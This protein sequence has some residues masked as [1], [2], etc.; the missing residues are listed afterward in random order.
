MNNFSHKY[1]VLKESLNCALKS[2][3]IPTPPFVG[4]DLQTDLEVVAAVKESSIPRV[5]TTNVCWASTKTKSY[6]ALYRRLPLQGARLNTC[7]RH[8]NAL[9]RRDE[10]SYSCCFRNTN[11]Q[12]DCIVVRPLLDLSRGTITAICKYGKLPVY[13]DRSN[14]SLHYSR[15]R[16]RKQILPGIQLFLNP[17]AEDVL[18]QFAE[19][20]LQE[21]K[22]VSR[23]IH[24]TR[25]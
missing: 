18:F 17:Q 9:A 16:I 15:N 22:L 21:Q 19:R 4:K 1:C 14:Q 23:V 12:K 11:E 13:P 7:S 6:R 25:K 10:Y 20:V 8:F 2:K 24:T 5:S 3:H